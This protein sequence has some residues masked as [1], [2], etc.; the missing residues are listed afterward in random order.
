MILQ[1]T[2]GGMCFVLQFYSQ[3]K[4]IAG[5]DGFLSFCGTLHSALLMSYSNLLN[6]QTVSF[7]VPSQ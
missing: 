4:R 2:R 6:A 1:D 5:P 3:R 7:I